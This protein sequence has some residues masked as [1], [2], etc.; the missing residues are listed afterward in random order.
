MHTSWKLHVETTTDL[1]KSELSFAPSFANL[2]SVLVKIYAKKWF[3]IKLGQ[4]WAK[5]AVFYL[6]AVINMK[7]VFGTAHVST[8]PAKEFC[9]YE[10]IF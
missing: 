9:Q 7:Q 3:T 8:K 5:F 6:K 2:S 4:I 1:P 10:G